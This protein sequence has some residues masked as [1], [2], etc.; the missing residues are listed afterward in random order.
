MLFT[1]LLLQA[2]REKDAAIKAAMEKAAAEYEAE[3]AAAA[4]AAA[5]KR[6]KPAKKKEKKK[7]DPAGAAA[8][9]AAADNAQAAPA[10]A[11]ASTS[12]NGNLGAS[13]AAAPS[14]SK[15]LSRSSSSN[16]NNP[17]AGVTRTGSS[18][19]G[20][21][22]AAGAFGSQPAVPLPR[23]SPQQQQQ[24]PGGMPQP[25]P[26]PAGMNR[27]RYIAQQEA[28]VRRAAIASAVSS[29]VSRGLLWFALEHKDVLVGVELHV[30]L[31]QGTRAVRRSRS[32]HP[33]GMNRACYI[34]QQEAE[35]QHC[36]IHSHGL[37]WLACVCYHTAL[38]GDVQGALCCARWCVGQ[39]AYV[40]MLLGR[41]AT[42][43]CWHELGTL[44]RTT[45]VRG[46]VS[47]NWYT[48][49]CWS[50]RRVVSL[51]WIVCCAVPQRVHCAG[52][53]V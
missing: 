7:E 1:L 9:A 47:G 22:S 36:S 28:E 52:F 4:K 53:W 16:S 10:A 51:A 49:V 24:R 12:S 18:S 44:H 27:A 13:A 20:L 6:E 8:A 29:D 33:A 2:Q 48:I 25:R 35:V 31:C 37:G 46:S 32:R 23:R 43:T 3:T 21:G 50:C 14:A 41:G 42:A 26:P 38:G 30:W 19:S 34:A 45:G 39:N 40:F 17:P 15:P 5:K 11:A